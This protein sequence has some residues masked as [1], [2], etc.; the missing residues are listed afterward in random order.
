MENFDV[1]ISYARTSSGDEAHQLA[2]ALSTIDVSTFIDDRIIPAGSAFPKDIAEGI[3]HSRVMVVFVEPGYF[4]RYWCVCEYQLGVS[5]YR[6]NPIHTKTDDSLDHMVIALPGETDP[7]SI[8]AHLPPPL[9]TLS[10]P[11]AED[12]KQLV[13]LVQ[14]RLAKTPISIGEQLKGFD[15]Y[16][17]KMLID[18]GSIPVSTSIKTISCYLKNIPDGLGNDFVGRQ[19]ILWKIFH[20]LETNVVAGNATSCVLHGL[21]GTGKTQIAAEYVWRYGA[22][23]YRGGLIWLNADCGDDEL[24]EQL[25]DIAKLFMPDIAPLNE[26]GSHASHQYPAIASQLWKYFSEREDNQAVLWVVDN[27]PEPAKG[28][29]P[30]PLKYW[31]PVEPFVRVLSTTRRSK[32]KAGARIMVSELSPEDGIGMLTRTGVERSWLEDDQWREIVRWVGGLPLALNILHTS[33]SEKFISAHSLLKKTR[34]EEP[35]SYLNEEIESLR[36]EVEESY[37]QG[38]TETFHMSYSLLAENND[39]LKALQFI[40]FLSF[41]PIPDSLLTLAILEKILGKLANRS[42]I[43]SSESS[44]AGKVER[45]WQMH[46]I[47]ASYVRSQ[48]TAP[49]AV[50]G[51]IAD[52]LTKAFESDLNW[53]TLKRCN[54]HLFRLRKNAHAFLVE[55]TQET[56]DT[57]D[58][59]NVCGQVVATSRLSNHELDGARYLGAGLVY[60]TDN[61]APLLDLLELEIAKNDPAKSRQLPHILQV[62]PKNEQAAHLFVRLLSSENIEARGKAMVYLGSSQRPDIVAV[63]F[64]EA[65]IDQSH[66]KIRD[67]V[68]PGFEGLFTID[69]PM[70]GL[71]L[72]RLLELVDGG[73]YHGLVAAKI[74]SRLFARFGVES[75]AENFDG[76]DLAREMAARMKN[77]ADEDIALQLADGLGRVDNDDVY[78]EVV[79]LLSDKDEPDIQLRCVKVVGR[80]LHIRTYPAAPKV[81]VEWQEEGGMILHSS[82]GGFFPS[83]KARPELNRPLGDF[84]MKAIHPDLFE[85]ALEIICQTSVGKYGLMEA[86]YDA[87]DA[88]QYQ[89]VLAAAEKAIEYSPD[90]SSPYMWRSECYE[91]LGQYDK[92]LSN[93]TMLI[94]MTADLPVDYR[95]GYLIK[96]ASSYERLNDITGAINDYSS[97]IEML[98]EDSQLYQYRGYLHTLINLSEKAAADFSEAVKLNPTDTYS[99]YNKAMYFSKTGEYKLALED[100]TQLLSVDDTNHA[101]WYTKGVCHLN[102][103]QNVEAVESSSRAILLEEGNAEYYYIRGMARDRLGLKDD[104][105]RDAEYCFKL[106]PEHSQGRNLLD[107]LTKG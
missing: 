73:F 35:A 53:R 4:E 76:I 26:L 70:L 49:I 80:Y 89:R 92:A 85:Q 14:Q 38:V 82:E 20:S 51:M 97:A 30:K 58:K 107:L 62:F 75:A 68:I 72:P 9:A 21:G 98:P 79:H 25:Y 40:A 29:S 46:R 1:F 102:L 84:V 100:L 95:A 60:W 18:G 64:L 43:Q 74:L 101:A 24:V 87:I 57:I 55:N 81:S 66:E 56:H 13:S 7:N 34:G 2:N 12:T 86:V 48:T 32:V 36:E 6:K 94:N 19:D 42:W 16:A 47:V 78:S 77:S 37:L 23:Y 88:G 105:R 44:N 3:L 65:L 45:F 71:I 15:D 104:A 8:I 33:L 99:L 83:K 31:C 41:A 59:I 96:R 22:L 50:I 91:A 69:S 27:L 28:Q 10:W 67:N 52:W 39:A 17:V 93:Q 11:Q 90:F 106:N 103:Q 63:P 61:V 5:L 54:P